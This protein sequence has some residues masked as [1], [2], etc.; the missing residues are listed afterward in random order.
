MDL[1]PADLLVFSTSVEVFPRP[2]SEGLRLL[3][4][5]H[6]RGGVSRQIFECRVLL[7]SSPR[8]WRCFLPIAAVDK[9]QKVFSTSVEVFPS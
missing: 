3:S 8:P 7:E 5:L 9:K 6:V 4:L 2:Q 1:W